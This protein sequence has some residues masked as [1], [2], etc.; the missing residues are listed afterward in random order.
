MDIL[1]QLPL[2]NEVCSKIF[3]YAC[4]SPH[5]GFTETIL[6]NMIGLVI[7][8]KLLKRRGIVV[9]GDGNVV[10]F[11][12]RDKDGYALLYNYESKQINFDIMHL[13]LLPNLV[14][15]NFNRMDITGDI[16]N[17]KSLLK[18]TY[19][20]LSRTGVS[21]DIVNLKILIKLFIHFLSI[22]K[23]SALVL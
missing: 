10:E 12:V 14:K 15:I 2:P 13:E 19:L 1:Y 5:S 8:D 4:K 18:L 22:R 20:N 3:M 17:I 21:G 11:S 7:Y 9:H 6:K 23:Q 16:T